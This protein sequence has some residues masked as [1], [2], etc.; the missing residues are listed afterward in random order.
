V[1]V[2]VCPFGIARSEAIYGPNDNAP[3]GRMT[4]AKAP[5]MQFVN[6][7]KETALQYMFFV[8]CCTVALCMVHCCMQGWLQAVAGYTTIVLNL[9]KHS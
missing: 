4:S 7:T 1:P 3:A 6:G 2:S 9:S 5:P 8:D